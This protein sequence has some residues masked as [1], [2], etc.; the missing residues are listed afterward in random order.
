M[1]CSTSTSGIQYKVKNTFIQF[2]DL[3][4]CDFFFSEDVKQMQRQVSEPALATTSLLDELLSPKITDSMQQYMLPKK[5]FDYSGV[6]EAGS[7]SE[8]EKELEVA[9]GSE[10]E[11][12]PD[13]RYYHVDATREMDNFS[14][15]SDVALRKSPEILAREIAA[16]GQQIPADAE[17][18]TTSAHTNAVNVV[19]SLCSKS[20]R[21]KR[22]SLID[23]AAKQSNL[24]EQTG[25]TNIPSG[26]VELNVQ[27]SLT[28]LACPRCGGGCEA[29]HRFCKFCGFAMSNCR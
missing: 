6:D 2:Y 19:A 1:V 24:D 3:E 15:R 26:N 10:P 29:G 16:N 18:I 14:S 21:R 13:S 8:P 28:C 9:S 4:D 5:C 7:G 25:L 22:F 27:E 11:K 12:E 23:Q 20:R 17:M